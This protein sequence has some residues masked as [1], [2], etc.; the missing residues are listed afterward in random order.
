MEPVDTLICARWVLPVEPDDAVLEN[1]AVA[2]RSGRI[3]AVLPVERARARYRAA[4]T[5]ERPGHALLPGL[6]NAHTHAAA[7]LL[8]GFAGRLPLRQPLADALLPVERRWVDPEYVRD[9]TE[10]AIAEMLRAGTTCFA[11]AH[12]W[13]DVVARTAAELHMRASV[14]LR[15]VEGATGWAAGT[16]DCIEQGMSLRDEYRGD[17]LICT[18]FASPAPSAVDDA[19]LLRVRRLADE[20][21]IPVAMHAACVALRK[22]GRASRSTVSARSHGSRSSGSRARCSSPCTRRRSMHRTGKRLP[23][24]APRSCIAPSRTSGSARASVRSPHCRASGVRVALGTDGAASN[25]D[26]DMFTEMHAPAC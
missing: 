4:S 16:D 15:V 23:P 24:R 10:L 1:H 7:T 25:S 5:I 18:H 17:P 11:D 22:S 26:L 20:L 14:G 3:V 13:P 8:R 9:G 12:A 19:T 21:E 2:I 6:V